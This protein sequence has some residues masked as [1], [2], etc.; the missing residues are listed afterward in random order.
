[1]AFIEKGPSPP[2][3]ILHR[4]GSSSLISQSGGLQSSGSGSG[5]FSDG[6]FNALTKF[7]ISK[8]NQNSIAKNAQGRFQTGKLLYDNAVE[9]HDPEE[10][11]ARFIGFEH[12]SFHG[13]RNVVERCVCPQ[14]KLASVGGRNES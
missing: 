8:M 13:K 9:P 7:A 5:L 12:Q 10:I 4:V 6:F 2:S 11:V 14:F 3:P 1:M